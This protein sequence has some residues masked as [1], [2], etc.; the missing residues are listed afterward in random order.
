MAFHPDGGRLGTATDD[1][2]VTLWEL[3]TG[4][5]L[6]TLPGGTQRV[7]TVAFRREGHKLAAGDD[8]TA[9][10]GDGTPRPTSNKQKNATPGEVGRAPEPAYF[11]QPVEM[12]R[13]RPVRPCLQAKALTGPGRPG[14]SVCAAA[15]LP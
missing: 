7:F 13:N 5:E 1:G 14:R 6:L 15:R 3:T 11:P 9:R 8:G 12:F 10:I 4:R 2:S